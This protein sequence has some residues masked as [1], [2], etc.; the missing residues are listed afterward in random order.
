M[1]VAIYYHCGLGLYD[2]TGAVACLLIGFGIFAVQLMWSRY[3][4]ATHKQGPLEWVWKRLTWLSPGE[5][6]SG[7]QCA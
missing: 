2:K 3:W 6:L 1:G 4:L 5:R 7:R